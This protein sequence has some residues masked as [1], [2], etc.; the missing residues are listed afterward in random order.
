MTPDEM[1]DVLDRLGIQVESAN[2]DEITAHCPAHKERTGKEDANPSWF[3]NAHSGKHICF[4]CHFKGGLNTLIKYC[5]GEEYEDVGAWL[6]LG[7]RNLSKRFSRLSAP[8]IE[9][10][11]PSFEVTESMLSAFSAPPISAL[12]S[13]GITAGAASQYGV[14]WNEE[15]E[16]WI[17]ALRDAITNKLIGWQEKFTTQK[18]VYNHPTGVS[19]ANALFGYDQY[20]SGDMFV[21]ESPLDVVRL[22][23]LGISGGVAIC[24]SAISVGQVNLIRGADR[25]VMAM[26]NDEAGYK[27][28][29]AMLNFS[30]S[31]GFECWFFN[32]SETDKK[33]IGGMSKS[34]VLC[35]I[36]MARHGLHGKKVLQNE[37]YF[38]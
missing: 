17:L 11:K 3:I 36:Q 26:D 27:A 37:K 24:G 34:E 9:D 4:S 33:D 19:K 21:L 14:Y 5:A 10:V 12:R 25:I 31:S 29:E 8:P 7:E 28:S 16:S 1:L 35:G 23:S 20:R 2:G 13:R 22:A 18:R 30:K 32:Y 38:K 15:H 6:N